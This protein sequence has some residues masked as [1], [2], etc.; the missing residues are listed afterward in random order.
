LQTNQSENRTSGI[1]DSNIRWFVVVTGCFAAI[2]GSLRFSPAFT[3]VPSFMILG[4][5]IQRRFPRPGR[6]LVSAGAIALSY[7]V[8]VVG[9]L[10]LNGTISRDRLLEFGLT[11]A[12]VLLVALCDVAIVVQEIKIRRVQVKQKA[13]IVPLSKN[14]RWLAGVTGCVTGLIFFFDWELDL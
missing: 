3:C 10:M 2:A 8:L 11:L 12:S 1:I 7:W 5:L 4:A 9:V 13:E 6:V 14:I